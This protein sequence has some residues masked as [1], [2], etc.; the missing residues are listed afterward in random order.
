MPIKSVEANKIKKDSDIIKNYTKSS[1]I[2]KDL[3]FEYIKGANI[4][5]AEEDDD[6]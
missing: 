6:G 3:P 2:I 1:D 5:Y 4:V